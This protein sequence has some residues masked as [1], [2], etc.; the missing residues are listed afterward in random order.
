MCDID[1]KN[2]QIVVK[3]KLEVVTRKIYNKK[4]KTPSPLRFHFWKKIN[5]PKERGQKMRK[6]NG[7]RF[8]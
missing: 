3:I 4:V 1:K 8:F 6:T 5:I 7:L 2:E